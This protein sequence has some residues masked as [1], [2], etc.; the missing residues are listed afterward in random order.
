MKRAV[1][2]TTAEQVRMTPAAT[3]KQLQDQR[4]ILQKVDAG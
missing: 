4:L 1:V 3:Q 2:L